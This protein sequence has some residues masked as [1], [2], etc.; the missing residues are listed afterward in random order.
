MQVF[1]YLFIYLFT[2][3]CCSATTFLQRGLIRPRWR[4][5]VALL[6]NMTC[7][8]G[9]SHSFM[10]SWWWVRWTPETCRIYLQ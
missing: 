6:R 3:Y 2:A 10:Y 1:I 9:C 4:K 8:R 7:T 5:V